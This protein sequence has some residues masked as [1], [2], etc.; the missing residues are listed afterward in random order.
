MRY[1]AEYRKFANLIDRLLAVSHEEMQKL[2][3]EHRKQIDGTAFGSASRGD[4]RFSGC[5]MLRPS[6]RGDFEFVLTLL[7]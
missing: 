5:P 6:K 1:F 2:E 4:S 7:T 3:A